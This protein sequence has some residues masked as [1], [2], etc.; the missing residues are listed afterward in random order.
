[1]PATPG[2]LA[3][4]EAGGWLYVL[5]MPTWSVN[6]CASIQRPTSTAADGL[7]DLDLIAIVQDIIGMFGARDNLLVDF[8]SI[9][10]A[11]QL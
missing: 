9:T 5:A 6:S 4:F 3:R 2:S 8:H 1:M 10:L 11:G 7:D